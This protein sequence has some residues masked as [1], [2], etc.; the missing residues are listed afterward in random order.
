M[1]ANAL[2]GRPALAVFALFTASGFAGIIYESIWSH[3]LKLFLGHAAFAQTVVLVMFMGGMA[4]G[5]W[6]AAKLGPKGRRS[7]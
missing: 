6:L 2:S 3:Y 5:A 4:V 7:T 1:K